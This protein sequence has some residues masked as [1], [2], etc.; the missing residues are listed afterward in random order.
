MASS[1]FSRKRIIVLSVLSLLEQVG[2]HKVGGV[3]GNGDARP[4]ES[5]YESNVLFK[6]GKSCRYIELIAHID[7]RITNT[8]LE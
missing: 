3:N 5:I 7:Y 4:H 1:E 6:E 8:R 2:K